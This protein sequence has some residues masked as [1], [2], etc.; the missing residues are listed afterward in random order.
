[1]GDTYDTRNNHGVFFLENFP[2]D[3]DSQKDNEAD[4]E[5]NDSAAI[6]GMGLASILQCQ[7]VTS[8]QTDHQSC[9][10]KVKL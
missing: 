7:N 1:M 2:S 8:K 6:P 10:Y 4:E 3:K 5:A 9:T